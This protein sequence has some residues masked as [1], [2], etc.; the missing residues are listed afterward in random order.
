MMTTTLENLVI[1]RA[2]L[3]AQIKELKNASA[4]H[5]SKQYE[6]RD[7]PHFPGQLLRQIADVDCLQRIYKETGDLNR[8]SGGGYYGDFYSYDE[9]FE[10]SESKPCEHCRKVRENKKA[11]SKLKTKL[12]QINSHITKIGM[13]LAKHD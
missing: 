1:Q 11:R 10:N 13:R 9:V 8:G 5:C 12:G 7:D 2:R 4:G 6:F 3:T